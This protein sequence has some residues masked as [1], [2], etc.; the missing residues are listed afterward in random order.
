VTSTGG[1]TGAGG[2][3][4][5]P[6]AQDFVGQWTCPDEM[7]VTDCG[8][9]NPTTDTSSDII[10]WTLSGSTLETTFTSCT[11]KA[12]VSGRTATISPPVTCND[13]GITYV[14]SGS[15]SIGSDGKGSLVEVVTVGNSGTSCTLTGRGTYTKS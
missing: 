13:N 8:D 7:I 12:T 1:A 5:A 2:K 4:S 11:L 15:F 6:T 9:G 3:T 14:I 10:E